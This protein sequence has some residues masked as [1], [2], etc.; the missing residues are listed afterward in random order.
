[1]ARNSGFLIVCFV[2]LK[3]RPEFPTIHLSPSNNFF[4]IHRR[5]EGAFEE[6]GREVEL[7]QS[8]SGIFCIGRFIQDNLMTLGFN[9]WIEKKATILVIA[10]ES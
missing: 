10:V 5:G 2:G 8:K 1:M 6:G 4:E 7:R 3:N 9:P